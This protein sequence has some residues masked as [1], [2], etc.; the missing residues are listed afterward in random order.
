MLEIEDEDHVL[1]RS[2][3]VAPPVLCIGRRNATPSRA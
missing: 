2:V 1:I 3:E